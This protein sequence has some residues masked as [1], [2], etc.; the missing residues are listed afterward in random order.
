M[1]HEWDWA[2][3][4]Q[5]FLTAIELN[6]NCALAHQRLGFYFNMLGRFDEAVPRLQVAM[7]LDPLSSQICQGLGFAFLQQGEYDLAAE[8]VR[9]MLELDPNYHPAYY[10]LG[11]IREDQGEPP[12]AIDSFEK[13]VALDGAPMFLAALGY[14]YGAH[15]A[16]GKAREIL[17][18]LERQ[19]HERYVSHYS[20]AV[21][22]TGLG[23]ERTGIQRFRAGLP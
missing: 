23:G 8:R 20:S 14:A 6:Q 5:E 9:E 3:A 18:E 17:C 7:N 19:S 16:R 15:G 22:H 4:E 1:L 10:L 11:W 13:L 21:V 12:A 2:G